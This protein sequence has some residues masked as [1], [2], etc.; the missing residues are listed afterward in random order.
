MFVVRAVIAP[1]DTSDPTETT[2]FPEKP[3]QQGYVFEK[4]VDHKTASVDIALFT[5][6]Y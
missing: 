6:L 2:I 3:S 1:I 5:V 4:I